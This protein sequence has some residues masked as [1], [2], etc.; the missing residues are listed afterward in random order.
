MAQQGPSIY[1]AD[2]SFAFTMTGLHREIDKANAT[3]FIKL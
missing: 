2:Q 3:G 1:L